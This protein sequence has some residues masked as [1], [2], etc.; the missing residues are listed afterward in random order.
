M[1]SRR[2]INL[3]P[4]RRSRLG[5]WMAVLGY[6]CMLVSIVLLGA[7]FLDQIR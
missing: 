4:E 3:D 7:S 5:L 2:L 6:V 1:S